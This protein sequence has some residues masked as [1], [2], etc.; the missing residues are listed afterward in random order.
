M[1]TYATY[2]NWQKMSAYSGEIPYACNMVTL[3]VNWVP[4]LR[5]SGKF[6][7]LIS[8]KRSFSG[9]RVL[10][11][12]SLSLSM[13]SSVEI[14][15]NNLTNFHSNLSGCLLI[16]LRN[17]CSYQCWP[18]VIQKVPKNKLWLIDRFVRLLF[19]IIAFLNDY[20]LHKHLKMQ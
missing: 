7:F 11:S 5:C 19:Q 15:A 2:L 3:N 1:L 9:F 20:V 13:W 6:S 8:G 16:C 14:K 18:C 10:S 17:F 12:V 4:N